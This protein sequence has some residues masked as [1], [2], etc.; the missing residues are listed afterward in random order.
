M[1]DEADH[2]RQR[3]RTCRDL[4]TAA[5]DDQSRQEL[6][7]MAGELDDEADRIDAEDRGPRMPMPPASQ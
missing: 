6:L 2:F 7:T 1:G 3:A 5:R 4:A